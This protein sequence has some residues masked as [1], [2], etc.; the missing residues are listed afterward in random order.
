[1]CR[2]IRAAAINQLLSSA[3]LVEIQIIGYLSLWRTAAS[4]LFIYEAHTRV[5]KAPEGV[6]CVIIAV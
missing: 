3:S 6:F 5:I 1:M 4:A 2:P